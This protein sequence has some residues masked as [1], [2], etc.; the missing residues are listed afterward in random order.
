MKHITTFILWMLSLHMLQGQDQIRQVLNQVEQNNPSLV[1]WQ[2]QLEAHHILNRTGI[3]L[4][5]PEIE[6]AWFAG[7]PEETGNKYN[8]NVRQHFEFPTVYARRNRLSRALNEQLL[9]GFDQHRREILLETRLICLEIIYHNALTAEY[10][11]RL[12]HARTIARA[13]EV[14]LDAGQTNIIEY[15][16]ARLNLLNLRKEAENAEISRRALQNRLT[17]L[18]GGVEVQLQLIQYPLATVPPDFQTWYNEIQQRNPELMMIRQEADIS[19]LQYNLQRS[20]NLPSFNVGYV[21]EMMTIEK[22]R[23]F[24]AGITI[25]LWE[26][27]NTLR[28]ARAQTLAVETRLESQQQQYF[29]EMKSVYETVVSLNTS[30]E[31]YRQALQPVDNTAVLQRAWEMGELSL[32]AFIMELAFLYQGRNQLMQM[33]LELHKALAELLRYSD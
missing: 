26:N 23:G 12:Q 28:Y 19:R 18:N 29:H 1:A 27:R 24:S 20:L 17:A 6:Y 11:L 15:N 7:T 8:L 5:D 22:F 31:E 33:E 14:M 30:V 4:S 3:F 21:S 25:P 32:T 9:T 16:K 2:R 10:E 13:Y